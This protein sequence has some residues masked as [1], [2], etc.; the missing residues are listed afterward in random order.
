MSNPETDPPLR[1]FGSQLMQ[2]GLLY[3]FKHPLSIASQSEEFYHHVRPPGDLTD[4]DGD[5]G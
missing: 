1:E 3:P 5:N 4:A 2:E